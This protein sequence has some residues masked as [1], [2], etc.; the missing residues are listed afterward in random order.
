MPKWLLKRTL[1]T[2][3]TIKSGIV[4]NKLSAAGIPILSASV[5]N[6]KGTSVSLNSILGNKFAVIAM[7]KNP[8]DSLKPD[9]IEF[10]ADIGCHFFQVT[11]EKNKFVMDNRF[12]LNI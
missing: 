3:N 9:Q 2:S 1:S 12:A 11:P 5:I 10:L 6:H 8:I 7:N 4:A